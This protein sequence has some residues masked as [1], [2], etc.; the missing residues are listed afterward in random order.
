MKDE[1]KNQSPQPP[2]LPRSARNDGGSE[3]RLR[4][5]GLRMALK[6][7]PPDLLDQ[8]PATL[9][10]YLLDQLA[11]VEPDRHEAGT[12]YLIAPDDQTGALRLMLVT[13][14]EQC[15]VSRVIRKTTLSELF[16]QILDEMKEM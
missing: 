4:N 11:D 2:G 6:L 12:V 5:A 15:A 8:A 16:R 9:E 1:T 14:D 10:K 13:L 3:N 7:I